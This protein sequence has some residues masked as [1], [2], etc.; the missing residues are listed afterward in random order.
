[1]SSDDTRTA[2]EPKETLIKL[3]FQTTEKLNSLEKQLVG[4]ML[5]RALEIAQPKIKGRMKVV[6]D[7]LTQVATAQGDVVLLGAGEK[8]TEKTAAATVFPTVHLNGTSKESLMSQY[9]NASKALRKAYD[10]MQEIEVHDR[11]YYVQGDNAGSDARKEHTRRLKALS[12]VFDELQAIAIS[13]SR[14]R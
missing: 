9:S 3:F 1:L 7:K 14:Q 4:A 8:G 6:L 2:A 12:D 5:L 13:I 11:D 10:A